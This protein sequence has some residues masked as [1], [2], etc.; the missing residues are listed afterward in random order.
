MRRISMLL[1]VVVVLLCSA[2]VLSQPPTAAQETTPTA[3]A[4]HPVVGTWKWTNPADPLSGSSYAIFSSDGSYLEVVADQT[5]IGVWRP[6]G[7]RTVEITSVFQDL[8]P[9]PDVF[10]PGTV[11]VRQSYEL[12]E[13]GTTLTGSYAV[14]ARTPDGTVVFQEVFEATGM[15]M[16]VEP[17]VPFGTPAVATPT[18]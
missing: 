13:A 7:E 6:V 16:E 2:V 4:A 9:D 1:S 17:M 15:R 14:D 3:M 5:G 10:E 8:E 11:T 18:S 12:D